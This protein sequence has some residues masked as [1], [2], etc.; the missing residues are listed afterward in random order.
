[1][2]GKQHAAIG[3]VCGGILGF[4]INKGGLTSIR[5]E[6]ILNGS[7]IISSFKPVLECTLGGIFG[8]LI[9]DIDTNK[10]IA[11]KKLANIIMAVI[12]TLVIAKFLKIASL[13]GFVDDALGV[14]KSN[15]LILSFAI[16]VILGKMSPHRQFTHKILGTVA[17][18]TVAWLLF[19]NY[20]AIGFIVGYISHILADKTTPAG[21]KFFDLKLPF[22]DSRNNLKLRF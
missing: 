9:V 12:F 8:A 11:S 16:L 6:D 7:Q 5:G 19:S 10:S 15:M 4:I 22:M 3:A 13:K 1:M 18:C 20:I 21:L 17:F 2:T 14:F